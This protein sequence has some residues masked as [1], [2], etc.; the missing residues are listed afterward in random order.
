MTGQAA[1]AGGRAPRIGVKAGLYTAVI[2]ALGA[3]LTLF[4]IPVAPNIHINLYVLPPVMVGGTS[5][6]LLGILAGFI[7]SLYTPVLWGWVGAFPY[8]MALG[9]GAGFFAQRFGIRPTIGAFI[10][11]I[12]ALPYSFWSITVLL[13][14]PFEIFLVGVGTTTIQLIVAG[15]IAEV[16]MSIPAV[17]KRVPRMEINAPAWVAN[18][19]LIRHP[20]LAR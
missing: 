10:A 2:G 16:I 1:T 15:A 11:H 6:P 19:R 14:I 9:F 17:R 7:G 4:A 3:I 5:G 12:L 13:G 20:W 8:A 18:N